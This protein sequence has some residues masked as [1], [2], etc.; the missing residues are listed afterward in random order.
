LREERRAEVRQIASRRLEAMSRTIADHVS[1]AARTDSVL[2]TS[3]AGR[4]PAWCEGF[5]EDVVALR[6]LEVV[7]DEEVGGP[8]WMQGGNGVAQTSA[9]ILDAD[10]NEWN[11]GES[12]VP[13]GYVTVRWRGSLVVLRVVAACTD[14]DHGKAICIPQRYTSIYVYDDTTPV[15][16]NI[17]AV[18]R[19]YWPNWK[20]SLTPIF[21]TGAPW[22][23]R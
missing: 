6:N 10:F 11:V 15:A 4:P 5:L 2:A 13:D 18:G 1:F 9:E 3:K 7:D 8:R 22:A 19:P 12:K 23:V 20:N 14:S 16:C 21:A 17:S